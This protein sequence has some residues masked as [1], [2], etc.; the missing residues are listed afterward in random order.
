[1]ER[2]NAAGYVPLSNIYAGAGYKHLCE[3]VKH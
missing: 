2:E 3:N 1:M